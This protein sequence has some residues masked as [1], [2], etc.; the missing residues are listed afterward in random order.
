MTD[1]IS[2]RDS[3]SGRCIQIRQ[4][5]NGTWTAFL[6]PNGDHL[7]EDETGA[8]DPVE[9]IVRLARKLQALPKQ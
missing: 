2:I 1:R 7:I 6:F 4:K 9:A 3:L 5:Q 8:A